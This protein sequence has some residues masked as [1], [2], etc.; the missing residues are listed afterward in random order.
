MKRI[1]QLSVIALVCAACLGSDFADSL[2]G[3]WQLTSGTVEGEAIPILDANPITLNLDGGEAGG[4]A[5]CN[6][7][8]GSY[9]LSQ[10]SISFGDLIITEMGCSPQEIMVAESLYMRALNLAAT[11]ELD[12]DL[13][14]RGPG[15]EL[16]F[17]RLEP[18]ADAELTNTVWLLDGLITGDA[19]STPVLDTRATVEFFTDGSVLGDTGCRPFS[20]QYTVEGAELEVTGLAS[21]GHECQPD[22][23]QQDSHVM[24]ALEGASRVEIDGRRLTATGDGEVGLTYIAEP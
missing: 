20:G 23:A 11:V 5:A 18:V 22:L 2:D 6:G 24:S 9:D 19:V 4:T 10:S 1:V 14:L 13:T 17:T 21:D 12:G 16:V 7:Y 3:S 8:G 15:T